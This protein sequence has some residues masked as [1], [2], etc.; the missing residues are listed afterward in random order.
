MRN[1]FSD[2]EQEAIVE[3]MNLGV[4]RAASSL[5]RLV[6]DE[7]LLSVPKVEF[8]QL[9]T[10]EETFKELLP[11][12]LAGVTQAFEGFINGKAALIFPEER[13]LELVRIVVGN[14]LSASEISELEQDTLAELGN[15]LL[16]SCLASLANLLK[17]EIN[18]ALPEA[19]SGD[20]QRMLEVLCDQQ[21][22]LIML[23]QIDFSL[24]QRNLQGYLVFIIDLNSATGFHS[25]LQDYLADLLGN[26]L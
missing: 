16:N 19:Y 26:D 21:D 7:V 12:A 1:L 4:G 20:Y 2:D 6:Q 17:R 5:S 11:K 10:A 24:R 3:L 18:T 25:A 15:I 22:S 9:E 13:S 23:V 14:E 8:V